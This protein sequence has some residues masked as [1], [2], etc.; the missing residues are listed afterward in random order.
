MCNY[1]YIYI[2]RYI[3]IPSTLH[4]PISSLEHHRLLRH[5]I[6]GHSAGE[7][8]SSTLGRGSQRLPTSNGFPWK[9]NGLRMADSG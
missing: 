6:L 3:H 7:D 1:V 4:P 8:R 9:S 2:H 5:P